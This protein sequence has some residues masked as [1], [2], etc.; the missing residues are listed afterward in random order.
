MEK[1]NN[2]LFAHWNT[3]S[4][5]N[6]ISEQLSETQ[7][8]SPIHLCVQLNQIPDDFQEISVSIGNT[9]LSEVFDTDVIGTNNSD[10]IDVHKNSTF[11]INV[12]LIS[13]TF[14]INELYWLLLDESVLSLTGLVK[15]E[16]D[17]LP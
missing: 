15:S 4:S 6:P 10:I 2:T 11:S 8:V 1:M 16:D 5:G 9:V 12:S 7:K 3:D 17:F 13:I 14:L